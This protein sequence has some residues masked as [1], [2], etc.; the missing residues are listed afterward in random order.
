M[1]ET[2]FN[3]NGW[4]D[5]ENHDPYSKLCKY[6]ERYC[7]KILK[8]GL[9]NAHFEKVIPGEFSPIVTEIGYR[10]IRLEYK[11][12]Q[13]NQFTL[14]SQDDKHRDIF[15]YHE[16]GGCKYCYGTFLRLKSGLY[17]E[18]SRKHQ[19]KVEQIEDE[20]S[21]GNRKTIEEMLNRQS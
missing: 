15:L 19:V 4:S 9:A 1:K 10:Q 11:G 17:E 20:K 7:G 6:F 16:N 12:S 3:F 18:C 5:T 2:I 13:W 14:L 8:K 21:R